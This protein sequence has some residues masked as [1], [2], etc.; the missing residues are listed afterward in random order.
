MS[1]INN[2]KP[3]V[4]IHEANASPTHISEICAGLEEEGILYVIFKANG[5]A[6][7]LANE[8]ANSSRLRVGIGITA[9]YAILQIR[10]TPI[11]MPVINQDAKTREVNIQERNPVLHI[12]L[13]YQNPPCRA[14]G[15]NAA[16][17]V[18]G[19]TFI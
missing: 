16:R 6:K 7:T 9:E 3:S 12:K 19:V 14:L 2:T 18:K 1:G 10:N 15:T 11:D 17:A 5:D 4:H 13:D 8:A